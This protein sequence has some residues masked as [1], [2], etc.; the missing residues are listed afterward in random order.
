MTE[1]RYIHAEATPPEVTVLLKAWRAGSQDAL[2]RLMPIVYEQL[3]GIAHRYMRL[4]RQGHTLG[5]TALVHEA[6]LRL[7]AADIPFSDR[8]HFLSIAALTMRRILV[9]HANALRAKKRG[10]SEHKTQFD[11]SAEQLIRFADND[12]TPMLD[13]D[14]ALKRLATFDGRKARLLELLYF[15]GLTVE[16]SAEVVGVS[17]PTVHRDLKMAK[18]WLRIQLASYP[19]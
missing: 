4:E 17:A 16:E 15:G 7:I 1:D 3:R 11:E 6:Y 2:E 8:A 5:T 12:P 19:G 9:D 10:G 13:L 14:D 18:A